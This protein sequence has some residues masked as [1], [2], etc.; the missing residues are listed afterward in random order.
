MTKASQATLLATLHVGVDY[1][2]GSVH[3]QCQPDWG[4]ESVIKPAS[5]WGVKPRWLLAEPDE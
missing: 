2:A 3:D 5:Q 4:A 1:D